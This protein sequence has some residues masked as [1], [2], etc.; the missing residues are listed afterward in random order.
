MDFVK[1]NKLYIGLAGCALML[2][3]TFLSFATVSVFGLK[4]SVSF[5]EGWEGKLIL[6][7]AVGSGLLLWF[8]QEKYSL[9]STGIALLVDL[10]AMINVKS[11]LKGFGSLVNAHIGIAPWVVL[12]G[13]IAAAGVVVFQILEEQGKIK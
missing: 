10:Y 13:I 3:G 5:I 8:K 2:I 11:Q 6:A 1:K 4:Q 7:L 12:I 9:I